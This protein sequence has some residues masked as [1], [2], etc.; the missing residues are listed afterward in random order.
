VHDR[1]PD[2]DGDHLRTARIV[3]RYDPAKT[4]LQFLWFGLRDGLMEALKE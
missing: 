3:R 1:N 2:E 4:W